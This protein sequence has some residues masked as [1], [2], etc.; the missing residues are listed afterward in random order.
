[1]HPGG[2]CI[3]LKVIENKMRERGKSRSAPSL[4]PCFSIGSVCHFILSMQHVAMGTMTSVRPHD[5]ILNS[6]KKCDCEWSV[7]SVRLLWVIQFEC[8]KSVGSFKL[9]FLP[10]ICLEGI[11]YSAFLRQCPHT[12]LELTGQMLLMHSQST[13]AKKYFSKIYQISLQTHD[14]HCIEYTWCF[15][16]PPSNRQREGFHV[17]LKDNTGVTT[18]LAQSL[19]SFAKFG[20]NVPQCHRCYRVS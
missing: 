15:L 12:Q 18:R 1:M 4:Q 17:N 16:F 3:S 5:I 2:H 8:S 6:P 20:H 7:I 14:S 19:V 13:G 11:A 10:P 9:H